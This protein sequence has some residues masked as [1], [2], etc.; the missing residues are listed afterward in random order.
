MALSVDMI[1][2]RS[3]PVEISWGESETMLYALAVG[4]GESARSDSQRFTTENSE[5]LPLAVLP[6]F[7]TILTSQARPAIPGLDQTSF[8]HLSQRIETPSPLQPRGNGIVY[9]EV[10]A[11]NDKGKDALLVTRQTVRDIESHRVVAVAE[12]SILVRGAGGFGG[13]RGQRPTAFT[14]L[15]EPRRFS[16]RTR[17]DQALLYRLTGD[18][19][20]IHSDPVAATRAG[21]PRP[22][23][24]GLCTLGFS[25]RLVVDEVLAGKAERVRAIECQFT[26]PVFPGDELEV[27]VWE[28]AGTMHFQTLVGEQMVIDAGHV[29]LR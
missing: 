14:P 2:T 22:L 9:S 29:Q 3:E 21:F 16:V 12:E 28:G 15:D 20:P 5:R 10:I 26:R 17:P 24:H 18:R 11:L 7:A 13:E 19:N 25:V 4:A 6:S 27:L 1:G 8:L 23:L